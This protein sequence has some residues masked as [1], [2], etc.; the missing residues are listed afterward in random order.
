MRFPFFLTFVA[1][2][3]LLA[4]PVLA[5]EA[6]LETA[7][8]FTL[9][10]LDGGNISLSDYLGEK[11][12]L[13]NFFATWCDPCLKEMPKKIAFL[14]KHLKQRFFIYQVQ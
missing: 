14:N 4:S 2:A 9:P 11:V 1:S 10:S 13:V 3:L 7:S 5:E 8:D 12:I 6:S